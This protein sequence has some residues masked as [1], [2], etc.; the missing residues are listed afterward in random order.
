MK[1]FLN[2]FVLLA[3]VLSVNKSF[4]QLTFKKLDV[5][6]GT[7]QLEGKQVFE[8]WEQ[9]HNNKLKGSSY[10]IKDGNKYVTETL[11]IEQQNTTI[12]YVATVH[13]QNEGKGIS[14]ILNSN[15]K[16]IFSFENLE[17]DFPKKIQ[18]KIIADNKIFV[19]V[20]GEND[21]GFSYYLIKQ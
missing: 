3:F 12:V 6:K 8:T 4:A 16:D 2:Y 7:W 21:Q 10:K 1:T 19:Q 9:D 5:L 15:E 11:L 18:Y 20:L 14:F 17:H 13:N